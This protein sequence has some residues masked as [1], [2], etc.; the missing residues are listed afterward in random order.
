[1]TESNAAQGVCRR[2]RPADV[3][4]RRAFRDGSRIEVPVVIER[5]RDSVGCP[6]AILDTDPEGHGLGIWVLVAEHPDEEFSCEYEYAGGI[7]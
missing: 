3:E 1:V 5:S 4:Q 2:Y 7:A 6:P